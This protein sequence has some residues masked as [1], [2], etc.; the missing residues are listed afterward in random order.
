MSTTRNTPEATK[1]L[2][3]GANGAT[4]KAVVAELLARGQAVTAFVRRADAMGS[5]LPAGLDL[6]VGDVMDAESVA[7]A[8]A[9]HDAVVVVLGIRENA[10]KVRLRGASATAMSVR[11]TGTKNI[12][13]AMRRHGVERLVVQ[14]TYGV[15]ETW[16]RLSWA[17]KLIFWLVLKPQIEDS[18]RQEQ[19]VTASGLEWVLVRPV[20]LSD[21][22]G[23]EAM[24]STVGETRGMKVSRLAVADVL[25]DAT[26]GREHVGQHLAISA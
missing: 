6:A 13:D 1:T 23:R 25:A 18:E 5:D 19:V 15:F 4:G 10:L 14:T 24:V 2:V 22:A 21:G 26:E 7:R 3:I 17:W 16:A 9:E 12:V 11:S 20:G 8:V